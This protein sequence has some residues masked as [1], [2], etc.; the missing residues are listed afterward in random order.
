MDGIQLIAEERKR[1]IEQEGW[2]TQHDDAHTDHELSTAAACYAVYDT[3]PDVVLM[4][5]VHDEHPAMEPA[6]PWS[7][8]WDKRRKHGRLRRLQIAGALIAAEIDR[9]LRREEQRG[10]RK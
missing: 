9:E 1:Q 7:F 8:K 5:D 10:K 4:G 2:T 6:W 3:G